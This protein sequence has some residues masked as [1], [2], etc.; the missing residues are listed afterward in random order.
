[1]SLGF[2]QLVIRSCLGGNAQ[3]PSVSGIQATVLY[4][5]P[6]VMGRPPLPP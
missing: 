3:L 1:M 5:Y 6:G 4:P 2:S